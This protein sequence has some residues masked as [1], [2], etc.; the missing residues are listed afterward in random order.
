MRIKGSLA[1]GALL[2]MGI[3]LIPSTAV[4]AENVVPASACKVSEDFELAKNPFCVG[5]VLDDILQSLYR[6]LRT[7]EVQQV[8]FTSTPL[9]ALG[10]RRDGQ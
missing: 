2:A 1:T 4:S 8:V 6:N 10:P 3:A 7:S 9:L 5:V